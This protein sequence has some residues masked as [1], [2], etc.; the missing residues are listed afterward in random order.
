M[1]VEASSLDDEPTMTSKAIREASSCEDYEESVLYEE[2]FCEGENT[3]ID[4]KLGQE[5]EKEIDFSE[6]ESQVPRS[7]YNP[8]SKNVSDKAGQWKKVFSVLWKDTSMWLREVSGASDF[9]QNVK[10]LTT[11]DQFPEK[12]KQ[13]QE[14]EVEV[15]NDEVNKDLWSDYKEDENHPF[16]KVWFFFHA[17]NVK[18]TNQK[19][20]K[21]VNKKWTRIE[22]TLVKKNNVC[23]KGI[24]RLN[25][26]VVSFAVQKL[27]EW[28]RRKETLF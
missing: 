19:E 21:K 16:Q 26:E 3:D 6:I 10:Q 8:T 17:Q 2:T 20:R 22:T 28:R 5:R 13:K 18:E 15:T 4:Y 24:F 11:V 9:I 27:E 7:D 23:M 1:Q 25:A 12:E 14:K